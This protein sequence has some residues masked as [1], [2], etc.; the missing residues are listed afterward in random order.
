MFDRRDTQAVKGIAIIAMVIHHFYL[1]DPAA[2]IK[3]NSLGDVI[4]VFGATGKVCVALLTI[5]SGYGLMESY[6]K[7]KSYTSK[8][9]LK[10]VISH[11]VQLYSMYWMV[12]LVVFCYKICTMKDFIIVYGTGFRGAFNIVMDFFGIAQLFGGNVLVGMW[13]ILAI[14]L[15]YITFPILAYLVKKGGYITLAVL[16]IPWLV[17]FVNSIFAW[18]EINV[19]QYTFCIFSFC[20]GLLLSQKEL[21]GRYNNK[22]NSFLFV[23]V[24][25]L[26]RWLIR[27]PFDAFLAL[28]IIG[29][30]KSM[31]SETKCIRNTLIVLGKHS[32]NIWLLHLTV[33]GAINGFVNSNIVL[34]KIPFF[35]IVI[36]CSLCIS[37]AIEELKKIIYY[38][39]ITKWVRTKVQA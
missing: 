3:I 29:F 35:I 37:V 10:F 17:V 5:L 15:M 32:A 9:N 2:L 31:L 1:S 25:V 26:F 34:Q 4:K 12:W 18:Y 20:L 21:I 33:G 30:E 38:D 13:Y 11:L 19:D 23:L 6:K 36:V 24:A 16:Y 8:S 27:L 22:L 14:I 28:A 7:V 39:K